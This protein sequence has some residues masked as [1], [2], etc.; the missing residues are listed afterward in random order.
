SVCSPISAHQCF[1]SVPISDY[2]CFVSVLCIS[3]HHAVCQ[4][5]SVLAISVHQ[6]W[7]SVLPINAHQCRL[8]VLVSVTYWCSPIS[9][10]SSVPISAASSV[11]ISEGEKSLIYKT[12]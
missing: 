9:A 7:L 4:C 6:C 5:P 12:L 11:H 10:S 1:V 3:A 2:Q 8:S